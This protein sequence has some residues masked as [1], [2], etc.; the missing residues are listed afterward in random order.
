V[1][2]AGLAGARTALLGPDADGR[3]AHLG[4]TGDSVV[5][6]VVTEGTSANPLPGPG[7]GTA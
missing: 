2:S 5:V 1:T 4:I 3:R 6:L 7:P